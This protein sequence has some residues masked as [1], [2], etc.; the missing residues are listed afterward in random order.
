MKY[1]YIKTRILKF[2]RYNK[3][4]NYIYN[5][6]KKNSLKK[7]KFNKLNFLFFKI[8]NQ[9][10]Y[11]C[12]YFKSFNYRLF[13]KQQCFL[14]KKHHKLAISYINS[15]NIY[16]HKL[17][18]ILFNVSV[19]RKYS[20]MIFNQ[21]LLVIQSLYYHILG[22]SISYYLQKLSL[23]LTGNYLF[24][25]SFYKY[26]PEYITPQIIANYISSKVQQRYGLN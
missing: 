3:L 22:Y 11:K 24:Q 9:H 17:S 14:Y 15:G 20:R 5:L 13:N 10:L 2:E 21:G 16:F 25:V 23:P 6:R 26:S 19:F 4:I 7:K 18:S 8:N 1:R 12:Y